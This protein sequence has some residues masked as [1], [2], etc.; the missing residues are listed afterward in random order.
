MKKTTKWPQKEL[1]NMRKQRDAYLK[2]MK[3]IESK[4]KEN[5]RIG[6]I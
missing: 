4:E 3:G 2:E 6:K 1:D 5:G